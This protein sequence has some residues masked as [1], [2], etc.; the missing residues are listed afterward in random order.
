[1]ALGKRRSHNGSAPAE[2]TDLSDSSWRGVLRRCLKEFKNDNLSD[3]AAA[4]TYRGVLTLAPGLLIMVSILGLL[5][6]STTDT[7]LT[8]IGQLAPGGGRSVQHQVS[9]SRQPR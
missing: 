1:M 2:L 8:N 5:G 3:W 7:L 6:R 4:L 9:T